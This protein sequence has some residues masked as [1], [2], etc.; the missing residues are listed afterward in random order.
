[1]KYS[2]EQLGLLKEFVILCKASPS[3]LHVPEL[4]FFKN[5]IESLGGK[6]PAPEASEPECEPKTCCG[7]DPSCGKSKA[8]PEEKAAANETGEEKEELES[9]VELDNTGVIEPDSDAPQEMGNPDVEVPEADSDAADA[10]R[11]EAQQKLSEGSFEE[12]IQLFTE[13]IKLNPQSAVLF[14]KRANA[15]IKLK[16]PNAA[17][18]DCN[19]ALELNPNSQQGLKWRGY[20]YRLLGKWEEAHVDF[21]A[22]QKNDYD[23]SVAEWI[24]EVLPNANKLKEHKRKQERKR[25]ENLLKQREKA[26][27][28]AQKVYEQQKKEPTSHHAP[29][30][31]FGGAPG[32]MPDMNNLF[33][34]PELMQAFTDPEVAQ[35]FQEIS[36]D[37]SKILQYQDNPK[38]KAVIEK[39]SKK[40]GGAGGGAGAGG[41]PGGFPGGAGGFPGGAGGFPGGGFPGGFPFGG[42]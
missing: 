25:D 30:E 23:E 36:S 31:E 26:R 24:K 33:S 5:W 37:P 27:Q 10:K 29:E 34:D 19:R 6:I 35:A 28:N 41:F 3:V 4:S 1:M 14:A 39:L 20:A 17:I 40:F 13:A 2:K 16:K 12:A 15:Y 38:V 21:C 8:K 18:R 9:D 42:L 32:G 11:S 22:A 7:G